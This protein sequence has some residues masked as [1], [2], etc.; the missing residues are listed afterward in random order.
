MD[1]DIRIRA[2]G[3][4]QRDLLIGMYDRFEPLGVALGLPPFREDARRDWVGFALG[5]KLNLAAFSPAERVV[6]HCFLVADKAGSAELAMFVHQE[7]RRRG[8]GTAL[9]KAALE[10]GCVAGLRRVWTLTSCDNQAALRVQRKCGFR[11][12]NSTFPETE[13][14]I[15]LPVAGCFDGSELGN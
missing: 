12:T 15:R 5:H 3:L 7:F 9:V 13:L 4:P 11:L 10:W 8:V 1:T 14:E 6:G 2:V